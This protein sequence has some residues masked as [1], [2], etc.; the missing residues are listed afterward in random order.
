MAVPAR[1]ATSE[2]DAN[3]CAAIRSVW[4]WWVGVQG[5]KPP[6]PVNMAGDLC[7]V[8]QMF[9]LCPVFGTGGTCSSSG[10][11]QTRCGAWTSTVF[12]SRFNTYRPQS[13]FFFQ[14]KSEFEMISEPQTVRCKVESTQCCISISELCRTE[15]TPSLES[16]MAT[17]SRDCCGCASNRE[18]PD[19]NLVF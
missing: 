16:K 5:Q 17:H 12:H 19:F 2:T 15:L 18:L 6:L 10:L 3:Y 9:L 1:W 7:C 13:G 8:P 4:G 14:S 11:F